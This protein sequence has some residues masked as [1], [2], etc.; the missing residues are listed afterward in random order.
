MP[1]VI[2]GRE[3]T[4]LSF[5][6]AQKAGEVLK[7]RLEVDCE[8]K[9]ARLQLNG[10][11]DCPTQ[12]FSSGRFGWNFAT[13]MTTIEP[14]I[15]VGGLERG[16]AVNR[17]AGLS[18]KHRIAP[19]EDGASEKFRPGVLSPKLRRDPIYSGFRAPWRSHWE[20]TSDDA[21][22]IASVADENISRGDKRTFTEC[23][24]YCLPGLHRLAIA[25]LCNVVDRLMER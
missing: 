25:P 6:E 24:V 12:S 2:V 18:L 20:R 11:V 4:G 21:R 16:I 14:S 10:I 23:R 13:T 9:C 5:S 17:G 7:N 19:R 8:A 3:Q 1:S 15:N 22:L